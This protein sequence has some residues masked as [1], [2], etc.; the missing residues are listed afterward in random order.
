MRW[1]TYCGLTCLGGS[2]KRECMCSMPV[3]CEMRKHPNFTH[4]RNEAK[5][6]MRRHLALVTGQE[7]GKG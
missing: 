3:E 1:L 6:R 7:T 4:Q 5:L 2:D